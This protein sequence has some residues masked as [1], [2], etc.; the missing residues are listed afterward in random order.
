MK[1]IFILTNSYYPVLGGLQT[2]TQQ[3]S[4]GLSEDYNVYVFTNKLPLKLKSYEILNNVKIRR[5][6]VSD[7]YSEI[8]SFKN[9]ISRLFS[10]PIFFLNIFLFIFQFLKYKPEVINIHFPLHQ[11]RYILTLKRLFRFKII[12]S[13]HGHD[14]LRWEE[15]SKNCVL[16]KDQFQLLQKSNNITACSRFLAKKVEDIFGLKTNQVVTI[17]NG[18]DLTPRGPTNNLEIKPYIF[19]FGRLEHHKG[20]DLLIKAFSLLKKDTF[21]LLIAGD[22]IYERELKDL[23][24][25]LN[26]NQSVKF[27]GRINQDEIRY[28]T[29]NSICN[30]IPSRR[31]PFGIT[32]LEALASGKPVLATN[33]G[34]IPELITRQF[35]LLVNANIKDIEKGL[36]HIIYNFKTAPSDEVAE[37]LKKFTIQNM[38]INYK[39]ILQK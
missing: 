24:F 32:I 27:L 25:K 14:V 1:N 5:F 20:F 3:L 37:Y 23:V 10:Y 17:Y 18:V 16:F 34:G 22:G 19:S 21:N 28:Y 4:E 35:G 2:V 33:V 13:F 26:L 15:K 39:K 38:I 11:I 6:P 8:N 31:E 7:I 36:L 29:V 9:L 30:V 12:T